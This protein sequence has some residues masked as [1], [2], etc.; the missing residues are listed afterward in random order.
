[1]APPNLSITFSESTAIQEPAIK[2]LSQNPTNDDIILQFSHLQN[3]GHN[4]TSS[5]QGWVHRRQL[6]LSLLIISF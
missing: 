4:H 3:R 6:L 5:E 1:M 2:K